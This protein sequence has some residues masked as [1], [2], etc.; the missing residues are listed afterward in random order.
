MPLIL[1]TESLSKTSPILQEQLLM[2]WFDKLTLPFFPNC[3]KH[4]F[5]KNQSQPNFNFQL[6]TVLF[7]TKIFQNS[8]NQPEDANLLGIPNFKFPVFLSMIICFHVI[9]LS[10]MKLIMRPTAI[11]LVNVP[12][13]PKSAEKKTVRY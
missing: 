7:K 4:G 1:R 8:T 2:A 6:S 12:T 10:A 13:I 3:Q 11:M 5:R 9:F